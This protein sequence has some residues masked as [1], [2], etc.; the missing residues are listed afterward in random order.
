MNPAANQQERT[1]KVIIVVDED[2]DPKDPDMVVWAI[3]FAMQPHRD[4]QVITGRSPLLEPSAYALMNHPEERFYPPPVGCSGLL[5]MR[6]ARASTR[7]LACRRKN[8]WS[9]H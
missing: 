4:A 8:T 9:A 3:S 5:M 1:N 6:C 2:I 7:P